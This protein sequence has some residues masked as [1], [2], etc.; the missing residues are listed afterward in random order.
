MKENEKKYKLEECPVFS[1]LDRGWAWVIVLG[2]FIAHM[3]IGASTYAV[4]IIHIALLERYRHGVSR[5]AFVG[6]LHSAL[7]SAGGMYIKVISVIEN[8]Y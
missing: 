8:T 4:G 7:I 2:S 5:T 1:D 3:M 6:A